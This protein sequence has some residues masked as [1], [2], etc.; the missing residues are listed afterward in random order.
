MITNLQ[1]MLTDRSV[2]VQKRAIQAVTV[3]Y[4][5]VF[6]SIKLITF[7]Y[8]IRVPKH[9]IEA[10]NVRVR[11]I[12]TN[13]DHIRGF[14]YLKKE[15]NKKRNTLRPKQYFLNWTASNSV[16]LSWCSIS[17]NCSRSTLRWLS[18]QAGVG[19][20]DR[21]EAAWTLVNNIKARLYTGGLAVD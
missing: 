6:S 19:I 1:M 8:W 2:A 18:L 4:R 16:K 12:F 9:Q 21:M 7:S 17:V 11:F 10:K 3:L 15:A 14:L 20:T 13:A 5:L